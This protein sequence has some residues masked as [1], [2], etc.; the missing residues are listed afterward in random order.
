MTLIYLLT[1]QNPADL[2]RTEMQVEFQS[3]VKTQVSANFIQWLQ[4][5]VQPN[6]AHRFNSARTALQALRSP[7]KITHS[8]QV[9]NCSINTKVELYKTEDTL[10][11]LTPWGFYNDPFI[12]FTSNKRSTRSISTPNF[13]LPTERYRKTS[14]SDT[15]NT[16]DL[17][18]MFPFMAPMSVITFIFL[19]Q[20]LLTFFQALLQIKFQSGVDFLAALILLIVII[21]LLTF[22]GMAILFWVFQLIIF[23]S[24]FQRYRLHLNATNFCFSSELFGWQRTIQPPIQLSVIKSLKFFPLQKRLTL[25]DGKGKLVCELTATK[26]Y[27]N[28]QELQWLAEE[29]GQWLDLPV[30]GLPSIDNSEDD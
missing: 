3:L 6:P 11:I 23:V 24:Q 5:M 10:T 18:V 15:T 16:I 30:K 1:G 27:L 12:K 14:G 7:E 8:Q 2:P 21:M 17:I 26:H 29:L 22:I 25:A 4:Q 9:I 13:H 28:V 20:G 19:P